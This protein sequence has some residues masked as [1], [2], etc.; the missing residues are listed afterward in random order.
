MPTEEHLGGHMKYQEYVQKIR[1]Y[2]RAALL[3]TVT[4]ACWKAWA[5]EDADLTEKQKQEILLVRAYAPRVFCISAARGNDY[6]TAEPFLKDILN[7]SRQQLDI[8]DSISDQ[9]FLRLE[10]EA[11][12]SA[13]AKTDHL[14][15]YKL[16]DE[17]VKFATRVLFIQRLLRSQWDIPSYSLRHFMRAWQ[18]YKKLNRRLS[19]KPGQIIRKIFNQDDIHAIRSA[20]GI[21]IL[22]ANPDN[23]TTYG[24][25]NVDRARVEDGIEEKFSIDKETIRLVANRI[26]LDFPQYREWHETVLCRPEYYKKYA[27]LP[28]YQ[29]PLLMAEEIFET[30]ITRDVESLYLCPSPHLLFGCLSELFIRD[31]RSNQQMLPGINLSSEL[32]YAIEDYLQEVLPVLFPN[33]KIEKVDDSTKGQKADFII[34]THDAVFVIESK[35]ALGSAEARM[36]AGPDSVAN[37]WNRLTESY[38]QCSSTIKEFK[39]RGDGSKPVIAIVVVQ[40]AILGEQGVF[41]LV[42]HHSGIHDSLAIKQIEVMSLDS[43][44]RA[45]QFGSPSDVAAAILKKWERARQSPTMDNFYSLSVERRSEQ[46]VRL[47]HIE[48]SFDELFPGIGT[49]SWLNNR[50]QN[51]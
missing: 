43:F 10:A 36:I 45:F 15:R 3:C 46:D 30:H 17:A 26:S 9:E 31:L 27:P 24:L 48:A 28:L 7:L 5:L 4:E 18:I 35:K 14:G 49:K 23:K 22:A 2:K 33:A 51:S 8:D 20:F 29:A 42:A 25:I 39:L 37:V 40:D 32:G 21:Y 38:E 12:L 13:I 6:R 41:D 16:D 44:E 34:E 11:L 50:S 47:T 19:G 1:R